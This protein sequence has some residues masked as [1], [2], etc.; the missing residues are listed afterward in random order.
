MNRHKWTG[1]GCFRLK[2]EKFKTKKGK[3]FFK[4]EENNP[5]IDNS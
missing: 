4:I 2:K 5:L 1:V 3:K